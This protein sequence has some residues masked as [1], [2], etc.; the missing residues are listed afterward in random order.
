MYFLSLE[1]MKVP[2]KESPRTCVFRV[3]LCNKLRLPPRSLLFQQSYFVQKNGVRCA[4]NLKSVF[5][6]IF[7][8]LKNLILYIK[9]SKINYFQAEKFLID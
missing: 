7:I 3:Q 6:K 5:Q 1:E 8:C 4:A 2:K 9:I